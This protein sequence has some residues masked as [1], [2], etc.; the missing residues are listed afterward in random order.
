MVI[1]RETLLFFLFLA[2]LDKLILVLWPGI[3]SEPSAVKAQS[4]NTGR[5]R[6]S[7]FRFFKESFMTRSM[8]STVQG[9]EVHDNYSWNCTA[10]VPSP[11]SNTQ[12]PV[13][14]HVAVTQ[15]PKHRS[16][17]TDYYYNSLNIQHWLILQKA[18]GCECSIPAG[19][20][21]LLSP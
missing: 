11:D 21:D 10:P 1:W 3:K 7:L 18:D 19:P 13:S 12:S 5:P 8:S 15:A 2:T 20:G 14:F 17:F 9:F 16:V 6:S 4:P